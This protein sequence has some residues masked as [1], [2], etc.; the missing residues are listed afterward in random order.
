MGFGPDTRG[1]EGEC[2]QMSAHVL[3]AVTGRGARETGHDSEGGGPC[4]PRGKAEG[5]TSRTGCKGPGGQPLGGILCVGRKLICGTAKSPS[6]PMTSI[7]LLLIWAAFPYLKI[8]RGMPNIILKINGTHFSGIP[9]E[10]HR[11]FPSGLL[12][13]SHVYFLPSLFP[14]L[15]P[16]FRP[17]RDPP[18]SLQPAA[19]SYSE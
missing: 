11:S 7:S 10:V 5:R 1:L 12:V 6:N 8:S 17:H 19:E 3:R 9:K 13:G 16:A 2:G 18:S 4:P 14:E 15:R